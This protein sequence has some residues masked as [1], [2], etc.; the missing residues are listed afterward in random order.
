MSSLSSLG[1]A[2]VLAALGVA[3]VL[4]WSLLR[5]ALSGPE[6]A[7]LAYGS[8]VAAAVTCLGVLV[9]AAPS[10]LWS[11][12][13]MFFVVLA[14]F[15]V[16]LMAFP[17]AGVEIPGDEVGYVS[18][19]FVPD[20]H[21]VRSAWLVAQ[22]LL[23]FTLGYVLLGRR[24]PTLAN[25]GATRSS[26]HQDAAAGMSLVGTVI[27]VATVTYVLGLLAIVEPG[28][29]L[30]RGGKRV[31][32]ATVAAHPSLTVGVTGILTGISLVVAGRR[33]TIRTIG[34][35]FFALFAAST[36]VMGS[37]SS[38]LY[39]A[40]GVVVV[41]ARLRPMPRQLVAV[42]VVL[43]GLVVISGVERIRDA[44]LAQ[45]G[46][47]QILG[48]PLAATAEMGATLRPV[49]ETVSWVDQGEEHRHGMSYAIGSIRFIELVAG[50]DREHS[51]V[52]PRLIGTLLRDRVQGYEIGYSAV[53]EAF[54]NFG[55]IGAALFFVAV[56]AL[57]GRW[58]RRG[59]GRPV[60]AALYGV[61]FSALLATVR[62]SSVTTFST[63]LLGFA[64]IAVSF[65]VGRLL[66]RFAGSRSGRPPAVIEA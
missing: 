62:A 18:S 56:G 10:G 63:I 24:A 61:V 27:V 28:L 16:P 6:E 8:A 41:L 31:Y 15:H 9:R 21:V 65:S 64:A 30:G 12:G 48:S 19:W 29:F 35:A 14:L 42:V 44:G 20:A 53:A 5:G 47:G 3:T 25:E 37:R 57:L 54:L 49:V 45:A 22:A 60:G 13:P 66:R 26:A 40:V 33:S 52:D 11:G 59:L 7:T 46:V 17:L 2:R 1:S 32:D 38:A 36:L 23:G 43:S 51:A 50:I 34:L 58:D 4:A 39:A 55:Q